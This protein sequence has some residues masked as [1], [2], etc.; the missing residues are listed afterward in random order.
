MDNDIRES[1]SQLFLVRLWRESSDKDG[2]CHGKVQ[3]VIS[4]SVR[5]FDDLSQLMQI[6]TVAIQLSEEA[7]PDRPSE[8]D[9]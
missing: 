1:E 6:L 3:H 7:Y 9:R 2:Q 4:G 8:G 5:L